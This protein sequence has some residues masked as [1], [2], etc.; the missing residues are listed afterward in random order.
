VAEQASQRRRL[1]R[2]AVIWVVMAAIGIVGVFVVSGN[3]PELQMFAWWCTPWR[4]SWE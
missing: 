2:N 3:R 4:P 1:P